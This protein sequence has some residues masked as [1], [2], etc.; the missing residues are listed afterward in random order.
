MNFIN[1]PLVRRFISATFFA[2]AFVWVAVEFYDVEVE[3]VR[4][5][6]LYSVGLVALM[7][8]AGLLFFPFV[9]LFR[10]KP[11]GMLEPTEHNGNKNR[12][13]ENSADTL[14]AEDE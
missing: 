7:V 8:L 13:C 1:D 5:L 6:F 3:V 14:N 4:L 12:L 10:K 11:S 2:S 9:S